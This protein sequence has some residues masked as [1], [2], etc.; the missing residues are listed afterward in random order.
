MRAVWGQQYGLEVV[1]YYALPGEP[2]Y[3]TPTF[4]RSNAWEATR[5]EVM[6]VRDGVGINEVQNFGKY[7]RH[8][9]RMPAPGWTGSWP[10]ISP[11]RGGCR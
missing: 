11:N 1:N 10:G 9:R 8:R 2:L 5:Q 7:R 6:A 3:E 4:K